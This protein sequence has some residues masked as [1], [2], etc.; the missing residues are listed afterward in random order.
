[1]AAVTLADLKA[2]LNLT[3]DQDDQLLTGKLEAARAWVGAYTASDP[4]LDTTP[5]A[6]NEAILQLAAH[7]Y[8]NREASLVGVTASALPFGFL[9]LLAPYRAFSF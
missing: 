5:A 1:M 3:T 2:H 9:D 4:S 8:E 7:L 6:I